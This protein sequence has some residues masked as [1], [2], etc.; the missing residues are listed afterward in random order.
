MSCCWRSRTGWYWS[1]PASARRT[2]ATATPRSRAARALPR[3]RPRPHGR[4]LGREPSEAS[5]VALTH[6]DLDHAGGIPHLAHARIHLLA[7]EAAAI[8]TGR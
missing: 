1:A 3:P 7:A 6:G 8:R 2:C 4:A 5:D